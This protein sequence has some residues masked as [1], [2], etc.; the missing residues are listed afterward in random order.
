MNILE[1]VGII[2]F[3]SAFLLGVIGVIVGKIRTG[4]WW[5]GQGFGRK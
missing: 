5:I 2:I 4:N 1:I 3:G